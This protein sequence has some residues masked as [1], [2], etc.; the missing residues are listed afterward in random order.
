MFSSSEFYIFWGK[1]FGIWIFRKIAISSVHRSNLQ[2]WKKTRSKVGETQPLLQRQAKKDQ[3]KIYVKKETGQTKAFLKL[4]QGEGYDSK[5]KTD[6]IS[7]KLILIIFESC[8]TEI[9]SK[10][11]YSPVKNIHLREMFTSEKCSLLKNI[12]SWK[13]SPLKNIHPWKM[14]TPNNA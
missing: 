8:H 7:K 5:P 3:R 13:Y 6:I 12:H 10:T 4:Q 1:G 9:S 14:F 2:L 11:Y